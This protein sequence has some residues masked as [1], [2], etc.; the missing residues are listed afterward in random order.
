M[1]PYFGVRFGNAD[2]VHS[3]GREAASAVDGAR[4]EIAAMLGVRQSEVFFTS[5]GTESNNW[6]IK[7][8]ADKMYA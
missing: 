5:C 1:L 4:R 6:A 2:S 7:G 3:F 8:V